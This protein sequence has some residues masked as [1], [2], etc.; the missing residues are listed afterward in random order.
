MAWSLAHGQ[1]TELLVALGR[2]PHAE[3][4]PD[5]HTRGSSATCGGRHTLVLYLLVNPLIVFDARCM[6]D[7]GN[8]LGVLQRGG[9]VSYRGGNSQPPTSRSPSCLPLNAAQLAA[10][11]LARSE[12]RGAGTGPSWR[13]LR[14][15]V[16]LT[17]SPLS[18]ARTSRCRP[19]PERVWCAIGRRR[20]PCTVRLRR[21]ASTTLIELLGA[22]GGRE[23]ALAGGRF[24]FCIARPE[25]LVDIGRLS[26]LAYVGTAARTRPLGALTRHAA[27]SV[28][29]ALSSP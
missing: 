3:A 4:G 7:A 21:T 19:R 12:G 1:L 9:H 2:A 14:D 28:S 11:G 27:G 25:K 22:G 6:V 20:D 29:D 23:P 26:D 10:D 13:R 15:A 5:P 18:G 24:A 8:L 16:V 17:R